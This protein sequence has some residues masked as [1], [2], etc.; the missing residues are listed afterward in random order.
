MTLRIYTKLHL[1][2][3]ALWLSRLLMVL[4]VAGVGTYLWSEVDRWLYERVHLEKIEFA[5]PLPEVGPVPYS[6]TIGPALRP[7]KAASPNRILSDPQVIGQIEIPKLAVKAVVRRGIDSTTLRR[8]IGHVPGT[9]LPGGAGNSVLAGHRNTLFAPLKGIARGD[10]IRI[11][12][13]SG[14]TVE[15]RVDY[16]AIVGPD[17]VEVM[18][19]S[20]ETRLTLITCYPFDFIGP[21]PRRFIVGAAIAFAPPIP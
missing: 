6:Q 18:E 7:I 13:R 12:L 15:Y 1:Q 4:G 14:G 5:T 19:T 9:A 3:I 21:S 16:L 10:L 8:S 20:L 11:R 2:P 17:A